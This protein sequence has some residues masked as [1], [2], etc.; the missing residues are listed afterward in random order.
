M[1]AQ[2]KKPVN[3]VNRALAVK[4]KTEQKLSYKQ[5]GI[6]Q[7]VDQA[8]VFRAI[9]HLIPTDTT[10]YFKANRADIFARMEE[11]VMKRVNVDAI[12]IGNPRAFKD[13]MTGVGIL[14]DKE[15]LERG[16]STQNISYADSNARVQELRKATESKLKI[17]E[18]LKAK[19]EGRSTPQVTEGDKT[20]A[21][22][23]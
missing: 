19:V 11:R 12:K 18:E 5:I 4:Q 7:G 23:V 17:L 8:A 14:Y 13:A 9:H 21:S 15:R 22:D 2:A 20:A 1:T 6:L 10:Q 3:R 16:Q